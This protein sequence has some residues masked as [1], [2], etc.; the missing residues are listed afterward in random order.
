MKNIRVIC[1]SIQAPQKQVVAV[2][3]D[4][5]GVANVINAHLTSMWNGRIPLPAV[6]K[7]EPSNEKPNPGFGTH[8]TRQAG[9]VLTE[10]KMVEKNEDVEYFKRFAEAHP[11]VPTGVLITEVSNKDGVGDEK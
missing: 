1:S 10:D 11:E 8:G 7:I 5:E 2:F 4:F 3:E 9:G 6:I